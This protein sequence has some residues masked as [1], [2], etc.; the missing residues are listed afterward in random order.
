MP[1][2][3][4]LT[5]QK[6]GRLTIIDRAPNTSQGTTWNC[7]CDCGKQV[8]VSTRSLR[9]GN[10]KSCGCLH[11]EMV[12]QQF[13]KNIANQRFG[14]LIALQPTKERKHGSVVWECLCDCGNI[15]YVT[16]ELLLASKTQ[17]CGC[18]HSRGNQKI[19]QVLQNN[20]ILYIAEYPIRI[21]QINYY[22]DFALLDTN[23]QLQCFIE[24]DGI[25]HFEQDSYHGWNNVNNWKKTQQN[26]CIKNKY[27]KENNIPLIRISYTDYDK[28]DINY[29]RERIEKECTMDL[30]LK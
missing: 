14:N 12:S 21:Q 19:K 24:Y 26:D 29:L 2:F 16:A 27:C 15:H 4:D 20:N 28:I 11:K 18:I 25:L 22:F 9:S 30:L 5:G 17:S 23:N 13:S 1:K 6:Y 10:T 3:I 8:Q 7:I